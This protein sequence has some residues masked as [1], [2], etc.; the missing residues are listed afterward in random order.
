MLRFIG[1]KDFLDGTPMGHT[2]FMLEPYTDMPDFRSNTLIEPEYLKT[3][4][5]M[6]AE[7]DV[8]VRLHAC[9]DAAVR[10]GLDAYQYALELHGDKR[11][12]PL[13]RAYRKLSRL[14]I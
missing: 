9:G 14:T 13:H 8:K 10:L 6:M 4:V 11:P 3:R 1:V 2:G 5:A 7:N 12:S